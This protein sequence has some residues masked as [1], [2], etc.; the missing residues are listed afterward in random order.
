[1]FVISKSFTPFHGI[2]MINKTLKRF[3]VKQQNENFH[4]QCHKQEKVAITSE[5]ALK[6]V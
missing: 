6:I 5:K 4:F 2:Q 1:M 3:L